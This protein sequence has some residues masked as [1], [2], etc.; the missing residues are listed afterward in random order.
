MTG[1]ISKTQQKY[2]YPLMLMPEIP[3]DGG[4][5][6]SINSIHY[7]QFNQYSLPNPQLVCRHC[8]SDVSART[9]AANTPEALSP[10]PNTS[11]LSINST[12][13]QV[14]TEAVKLLPQRSEKQKIATR[15]DYYATWRYCYSQAPTSVRE[16]E[17]SRKLRQLVSRES[18]RRL[19]TRSAL[20]NSSNEVL[21]RLTNS[22]KPPF[23]WICR[24]LLSA[25]D[26]SVTVRHRGAIGDQLMAILAHR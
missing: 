5:S 15:P 11:K 23:S 20:A 1:Q 25:G 18:H 19:G 26:A 9:V 6:C 2:G 4:M 12:S 7:G 14:W 24:L 22:R 21:R 3:V 17:A 10:Q 13:T 8:A 16:T